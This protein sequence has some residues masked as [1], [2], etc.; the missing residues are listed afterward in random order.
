MNGDDGD[1]DDDGTLPVPSGVA[2]EEERTEVQERRSVSIPLSTRQASA[3]SL[4]ILLVGLALLSGPVL[5]D[6]PDPD[7]V[8]E[9]DAV[10]VE[11]DTGTVG[12]LVGLPEVAYVAGDTA[13]AV[14]SAAN[15]TYTRTTAEPGTGRLVETFEGVQ[16]VR[17]SSHGGSTGWTL[18]S[19]DRRSGSTRSGSPRRR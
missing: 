7:R 13:E 17:E 18:A 8:Y 5:G 19:R 1:T 2:D 9:Y 12:V 4:L 10:T 15:S 16:F 3:L 14:V 6:G 11:P